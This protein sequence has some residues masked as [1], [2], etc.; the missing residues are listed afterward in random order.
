MNLPAI[1]KKS[2]SVAE[3]AAAVIYVFILRLIAGAR[4]AWKNRVELAPVVARYVLVFMLG[5]L[6][7]VLMFRT[8]DAKATA[9]V[10]FTSRSEIVAASSASEA[11]AVE[12]EIGED[13]A[14][15][16][17]Q[18]EAI[19]EAAVAREA[20]YMARVLYGTARYHSRETQEAVCWCIINRVESSLFPNTVE[21]VCAQPVQWVGY[22][23]NNPVTQELYDVAMGVLDTWHSKGIRMIPQDYIYLSWSEKEIVLRTSFNETARTHYWHVTG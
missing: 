9:D 18:Q 21:E 16:A 3:K 6:M 2:Q 20:Q 7:S 15:I 8:K 10:P 17:A 22:S 23:S 13:P 5:M 19:R 12:A 11:A 4:S 14:V 1:L